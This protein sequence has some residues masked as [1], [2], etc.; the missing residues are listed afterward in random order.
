M[1]PGFRIVYADGFLSKAYG[2]DPCNLT[3]DP[4]WNDD[5]NTLPAGSRRFTVSAPAGATHFELFPIVD[6]W[7]EGELGPSPWCSD[8][9]KELAGV[10]VSVHSVTATSAV[11]DISFPA[12]TVRGDCWRSGLLLLEDAGGNILGSH[13]LDFETGQVD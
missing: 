11:A 1:T 12:V 4:R 7:P 13:W 5:P 3:A 6:G 9:L 10:D 8:A 2:A